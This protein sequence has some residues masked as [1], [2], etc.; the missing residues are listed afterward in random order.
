MNSTDIDSMHT[1]FGL[2]KDATQS[3]FNVETH[4]LSR[5]SLMESNVAH[6]MTGEEQNKECVINNQALT[7]SKSFYEC[8]VCGHRTSLKSQLIDHMRIHT[9]NDQEDQISVE[10]VFIDEIVKEEPEFDVSNADEYLSSL[11]DS[12]NIFSE[13]VK[14]IEPPKSNE[15]IEKGKRRKDE[16]FKNSLFA[17]IKQQIMA[18]LNLSFSSFTFKIILEIILT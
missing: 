9:V 6:N 12:N 15:E 11:N 8:Y 16:Q 17:N 5:E 10:A 3:G 1:N 18:T 13:T 14:I 4:Q 7:K 2:D